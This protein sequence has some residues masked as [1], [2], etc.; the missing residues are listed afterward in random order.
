MRLV[1]QIVANH[2]RVAAI[3]ARKDDPVVDPLLLGVARWTIPQDVPGPALAGLDAHI[4]QNDHH[5]HLARTSQDGVQDVERV[6]V[7]KLRIGLDVPTDNGIALDELVRERQTDRIEPQRF[8]RAQDVHIGAKGE[9][10]GP[11]DGFPRAPPGS[12]AGQSRQ[13]CPA[14]P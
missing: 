12:R 6:L 11:T 2:G 3:A 9:P 14:L 7:T 13:R 5:A 1:V 10:P 8:D 4:A